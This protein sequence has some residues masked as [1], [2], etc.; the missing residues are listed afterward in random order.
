MRAEAVRTVDAGVHSQHARTVGKAEN[1]R[2]V[3]RGVLESEG[4]GHLVPAAEALVEI[5][6]HAV[7]MHAADD[8]DL[9]VVARAGGEVRQRIVVQQ[10]A[11]LRADA[12]GWND[13]AG[14]GSRVGADPY[15]TRVH[16]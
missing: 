4:P 8:R 6:L 13:V 14:A 12:V 7:L 16:P 5:Q 15:D 2:A 1:V 10:R 9:V 3:R 11:R